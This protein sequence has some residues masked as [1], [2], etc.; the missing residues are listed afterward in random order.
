MNGPTFVCFRCGDKEQ[1]LPDPRVAGRLV[2]T[3]K[4]WQWRDLGG[5]APL[6][7]LTVCHPCWKDI[8]D[9][10]ATPGVPGRT[11]PGVPAEQLLAEADA[12][13]AEC[14]S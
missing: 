3:F 8:Y 6:P 11:P 2:S 13:I 1:A 14:E 10:L 7:A 9:V 12:L 5:A 4:Q